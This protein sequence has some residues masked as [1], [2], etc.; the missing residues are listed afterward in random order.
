MYSGIHSFETQNKCK[1][2][3]VC[4]EISYPV[5]VNNDVLPT[6]IIDTYKTTVK[7]SA[8]YSYENRV[9]RLT[10]VVRRPGVP[11]KI[12]D[13]KWFRN[14]ED[15]SERTGYI[16]VEMD[17]LIEVGIYFRVLQTFGE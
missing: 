1:N 6:N 4:I 17:L 2:V 9:W 10:C 15:I 12:N 8:G 13:V 16:S 3:N 11:R 14:G 5:D 7:T